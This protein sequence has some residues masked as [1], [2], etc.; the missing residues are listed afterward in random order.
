MTLGMSMTEAQFLMLPSWSHLGGAVRPPPGLEH[1]EIANLQ[2][3]LLKALEVAPV[4]LPKVVGALQPQKAT[5]PQKCGFW[6]EEFGLHPD[7]VEWLSS[8]KMMIRNVPA[9]CTYLELRVYLS[10]QTTDDFVLEM[11]KTSP[12]KCKGYAFVQMADSVA[13]AA[14]A[15]ALWQQTVPTR[16]SARPFKIHPAESAEKLPLSLEP[17][18][19][20]V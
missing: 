9:R 11:P 10:T 12:A 14:L 2:L 19:F 20:F 16:K 15:K 3:Q 6:S 18:S 4:T 13:L 5:Q 17:F 8:T 7:S 1:M